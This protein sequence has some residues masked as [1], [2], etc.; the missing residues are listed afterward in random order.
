MTYGVNDSMN[1]GDAQHLNAKFLEQMRSDQP[2][3]GVKRGDRYFQQGAIPFEANPRLKVVEVQPLGESQMFGSKLSHHAG[4]HD[5]EDIRPTPE[6]QHEAQE[7][8]QT[9]KNDSALSFTKG[10]PR[11]SDDLDGKIVDIR[12]SN[13]GSRYVTQGDFPVLEQAVN[14]QKMTEH[15]SA[16]S[17]E[18]G[19]D[20]EHQE[21]V[22]HLSTLNQAQAP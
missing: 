2:Y 22:R 14:T 8:K 21:Y 13:Q 17:P 12:S 18:M 6:P 16:I 5:T 20:S 7:T 3:Y 9:K 10:N 15:H 1:S 4:M 11:Q 19:M